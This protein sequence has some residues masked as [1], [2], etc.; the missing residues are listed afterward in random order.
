MKGTIQNVA[1]IIL[2]LQMMN[3]SAVL[4]Q[5]SK[6]PEITRQ[7][8]VDAEKQKPELEKTEEGE[9]SGNV[10]DCEQTSESGVAQDSADKKD[11]DECKALIK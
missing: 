7:E 6:V 10:E 4:A 5:E 2:S 1:A 3:T 8:V 9:A 11:L